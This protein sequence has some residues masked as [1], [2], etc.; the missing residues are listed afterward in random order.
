MLTP[1]SGTGELI[2]PVYVEIADYYDNRKAAVTVT[3]DDWTDNTWQQFEAMSNMLTA[4]KMSFTG[5]VET[6][7]YP[8]WTQI[9]HWL[10]QG[11]LE[12][13]SHS[14]THP[15]L[16]YGSYDSEIG[17]S[18]QDILS[19]LTL[20]ATFSFGGT[21]YVLTWIEPYGESDSSVR[22]KL[23]EY[24]Y[25]TARKVDI[26]DAWATWDSDY[27][28]FDRI[29]FSMRMEPPCKGGVD[30]V[31]ILNSK[32]DNVYNTG[33]I[34]HLMTHP[35]NVN[36]TAGE[37]A[38]LHTSYISNR[39]DVWYVSFG[40]LYLYRWI[41]TQNVVQV[42]ST[43]SQQNKIFKINISSTDR[44]HYGAKYPITYVF[45][46]P[47]S[48]ITANANYRFRE[49]DSWTPLEAKTSSDFF[50]GINAVR[51]DFTDHKAYI[52]IGFSDVSNEIFLQILPEDYR[53]IA[54]FT[55]SPTSGNAPL[56]VSFTENST[57][58]DGIVTWE[59]DFDGDTVVDST[60]P[61]PTYRY[62]QPGLYTVSLTVYE[63]DGDNDTE[64]KIDYIN[65]NWPP[66]AD[67]GGSYTAEEGVT[68]TF[69]G[70]GSYDPDGDVISYSW[71][72]GDGQTSSEQNPTHMYTHDHTYPVT[73]TVTD[74]NSATDA[75]TTT[76]TV[77]DTAPV[78]DFSATPRSGPEP[79]T[80][81]FTDTST[82]YD[83]IIAWA[84]DFDSDDVVDSTEQNPS[85]VFDQDGLYTVTLTVYE[86][87]GNSA[88]ETKVDYIIVSDAEP[89]A[90][91]TASPTSGPEP[92]IVGFTDTSTSQDGIVSWAWDFDNDDVVDSTEQNP[93]CTYSS[94]GLYTVS[95]TVS[96]DDGDNDT[97]TKF[98]YI[99]VD[100]G[101]PT[102]SFTY[103][104]SNPLE[105]GLITFDA[106]SSI[107]YDQPLSYSW[108]FSDGT[109]L[110]NLT[111]PIATHTYTQDGNYV[112]TLTVVD[113]DGSTDST[114]QT[115]TV[116]DTAPVAD[117]SATL[118]SGP[119]PLT[120]GFTDSSTSYDGIIAWEWDFDND[121]V[122][123]STEQNPTHKFPNRGTFDVMLTVMDADG[124]RANITKPISVLNTSPTADFNI[125]SS[126]KPTIDEDITL[127]DQSSD[128]DGTIVTWLW[129]FGDGTKYTSQNATH[130]YYALGT[131]IVN[132]TVTDDDGGTD[133]ISKNI[134]IYD[135]VPPV[136]VDDYDGLGHTSDF[137]I[138]LTATDD[139]SGVQAIYYIIN[140][141]QLMDVQTHGQP[142]I[143]VEGYTQLE[144]WSVDFYGNE[145]THHVIPDIQLDKTS[146]TLAT[147]RILVIVLAI[148]A[149]TTG[150]I[151]WRAWT[152]KTPTSRKERKKT[153]F[154]EILIYLYVRPRA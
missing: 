113:S 108:N 34:Y 117:F 82:S 93:T 129:D 61:N 133:T 29:G 120:V 104:P 6:R 119:E 109:L 135:V 18:K 132:L 16:P 103:S 128:P 76:A 4:K 111:D 147:W 31:T 41:D 28:L 150:I 101:V 30:N 152:N 91:F 13:A 144:Y 60:E 145:E 27:G 36:W 17:G 11:Y 84:W 102:A 121:D 92:L 14:R 15:R 2:E 1:A 143:S 154:A 80:V 100:E 153:R 9:Q 58:H 51:F 12:V 37:Y 75:D 62:D 99:I 149:S 112:V 73:L 79:L 136:T 105:G 43:D 85:N 131:F 59:W 122:V 24:K 56:D 124:S 44:Q 22:Q 32:F 72:F 67:T 54:D 33:G 64:T 50:N 69:D 39:E 53:P 63:T 118:M 10:D 130:R 70:S 46:I 19:N 65:I 146:R 23:G 8:N 126:L 3:A 35:R 74:D 123:D 95:L 21:E 25:L 107:G 86:S 96:E 98:P 115:M 52:S 83:G 20:P 68:I 139:L 49:T 137:T 90:N 116:T 66:I 5:G 138:N 47:P 48:W 110:V 38:D 142:C 57:S 94:A 114:S 87:D 89:V 134:T 125:V 151:F 106:T 141:G 127:I 26:D 88:T 97:E 7:Y 78:A 71:D 42:T 81:G 45:D 77:T 140:D 55:A 148:G 40:L